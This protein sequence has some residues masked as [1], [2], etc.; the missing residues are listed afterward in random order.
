MRLPA[1]QP[2]TPLGFQTARA[3]RP[4]QGPA[5]PVTL[6]QEEEQSLLQQGIGV[7]SYVAET[8]DKPGAAVRG[9][10]AGQPDQL[11][12]LIP[13]SDTLG[14]TDPEDVG[15]GRELLEGY[16][17]APKN[18]P[19]FFNSFEDAAFDVAGFATEVITDPLLYVTGP[20]G[21]LTKT[22]LKAQKGMKTPTMGAQRHRDS[23]HLETNSS[24]KIIVF[25]RSRGV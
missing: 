4:R 25:P 19:G 21:S 1:L 22:G 20:L 15:S 3:A 13:F 9:L 6:T 24:G 17:L 5:P 14:I 23:W 10:L 7:L 18:I 12:N 8:L 16:G 11:L 2:L